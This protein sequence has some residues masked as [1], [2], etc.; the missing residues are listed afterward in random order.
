MYT[1]L[2][3]TM[4]NIIEP[5]HPMLQDI[6]EEVPVEAIQSKEIQEVITDMLAIAAGER[7]DIEKLIMVGLAAPQ[8]GVSKRIILVDVG[9][10][11][12]RKEFGTLRVFINPKIIWKSEEKE[13]GREGCFSVPRELVGIVPR[14]LAVQVTAFDRKGNPIN[15]RFEGFTARIFQHEIDHLDGLRFPDRV[16]KEGK[17]HWVKEEDISRYREEPANWSHSCSWNEWLDIIKKSR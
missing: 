9:V 1:L 8:V 17:L 13:E 5:A 2:V 3:A 16:G 10:T 7:T 4:L 14:H 11:P 6:A 15:E 12:Q